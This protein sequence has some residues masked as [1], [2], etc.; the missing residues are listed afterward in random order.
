MPYRTSIPFNVGVIP[1][2]NLQWAMWQI[3]R[4]AKKVPLDDPR[5]CPQAV[6]WDSIT[7]HTWIMQ[8]VWFESVKKL[9]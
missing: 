2:L 3:D 5:S 7:V 4:M 6:A 1:L 9:M 8:N